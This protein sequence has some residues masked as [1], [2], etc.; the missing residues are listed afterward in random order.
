MLIGVPKELADGENRAPMIPANIK[1]LVRAGAEVH[2]EAG[3][4]LGAG[5]AD[6]EYEEA[7][8]TI[9]TD[10]AALLGTSDILLRLGK[11]T[12]DEINQVKEKRLY[13]NQ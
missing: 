3:L 6:S 9:T 1:K 10:R 2:V 13:I 5:H 7:G 12:P 11:P 4:G 8:A